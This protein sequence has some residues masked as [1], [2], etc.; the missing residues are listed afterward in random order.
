ME[1]SEALAPSWQRL[2]TWEGTTM[3][4]ATAV[5]R[6]ARRARDS[7]R[8]QAIREVLI[9]SRATTVA[10]AV[11][12]VL[13]E[14]TAV[15]EAEAVLTTPQENQATAI[16][17]EGVVALSTQAQP[18]TMVPTLGQAPPTSRRTLAAA[19]PTPAPATTS[20]PASLEATQT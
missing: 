4:P 16:P 14:V 17:M 15:G 9:A 13:Q 5:I 20:R 3:V 10:A 18:P 6:E 11:A 1:L 19:T 8:A 2:R 12:T 7:H